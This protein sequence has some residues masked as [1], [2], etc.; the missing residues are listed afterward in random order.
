[1]E[2]CAFYLDKYIYLCLIV[3]DLMAERSQQTRDRQ[4]TYNARLRLVQKNVA[5]EKQ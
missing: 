1:M 2:E 3:Q 5:V 4:C